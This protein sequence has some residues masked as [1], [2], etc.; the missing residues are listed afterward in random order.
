MYL[1]AQKRKKGTKW[2]SAQWIRAQFHSYLPHM[3]IFWRIVFFFACV[4]KI[5][6]L[7]S[8][9]RAKLYLAFILECALSN[10]IFFWLINRNKRW[11]PHSFF[12]KDHSKAT[13]NSWWSTRDKHQR[14]RQSTNANQSCDLGPRWRDE[15]VFQ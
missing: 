10:K 11:W 12:R 14:T 5:N 3:H 7:N 6:D 8:Q 4:F 13:Y 2:N 15:S 1:Y 9:E